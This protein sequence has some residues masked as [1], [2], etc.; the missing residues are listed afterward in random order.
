MDKIHIKNLEVFANHGVYPE[1]NKLGQK[2]IISATLHTNIRKAAKSD[3]IGE[4]INYGEVSLFIKDYME[5]NTFKLLETVVEKLAQELLLK[6]SGLLK[7]DLKIDKPW[8]PVRLPLETV[9]VEIERKWHETFIAL[10][11]N[12]GDKKEHLNTAVKKLKEI[13]GCEVV[14]VSSFITTEPY[15][16]VEQDEFLNGCLKLRTLFT[17][18]E[19]LA[20]FHKIEQEADRVRTKRWGPRTLDLD[21]IFYDDLIYDSQDLHIPHIEMHKRSFVLQ[22]LAELAP[23]KRHPILLKTVSQLLDDLNNTANQNTVI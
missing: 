8:A 19:L 5:N 13:K 18:N 22:P 14:T 2:F 7:V 21:I 6:Y 23:Y 20:C 11:S 4:S 12:M 17:P 1:E 9:S 15:G 3:D 16:I 10:G